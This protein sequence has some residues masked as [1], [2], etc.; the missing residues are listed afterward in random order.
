MSENSEEEST[1]NV[2]FVRRKDPDRPGH[3]FPVIGDCKP[4]DYIDMPWHIKAQLND[5]DLIYVAKMLLLT[6]TK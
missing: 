2:A 4:E 6:E 5:D 3:Y 1:L